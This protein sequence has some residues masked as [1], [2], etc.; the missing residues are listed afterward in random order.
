MSEAARLQKV[1]PSHLIYAFSSAKPFLIQQ[2]VLNDNLFSGELPVDG[3]SSLRGLKRFEVSRRVKV[4]GPKFSGPLPAFDQMPELEVLT[5]ANN[6]FFGGIHQKFLNNSQSIYIV[7]LRHNRLSGAVPERLASLPTLV[8]LLAGNE[9]SFLSQDFCDNNDWMAG[10]VGKVGNNGCN[11]ILCPPHTSSPLGRSNETVRCTSCPS[12]NETSTPAPYFGSTTCAAPV[13]E[14]DVLL[15]LFEACK[16][17]DWHRNDFW[18]SPIDFCDWYGVGCDINGHVVVLNLAANNLRGTTPPSIFDLPY[19]QILYIHS[20]PI[21]FIFD[22]IENA[23]NLLDLRLGSTGLT[24]LQG[25]GNAKSLTF[26]DVSF[27][28]LAGKFPEE[29]LQ[30][31]NL[32]VLDIGENSFSGPLPT[33]FGSLPYL[34]V[35]QSYSNE[36]TGTL[37]SFNDSRVLH[38]I[39]F[40]R[41]NLTG[42][43]PIDFLNG[44]SKNTNL[45]VDLSHNYLTGAIPKELGRFD[46]M[47]IYLRMNQIEE[48]PAILCSKSKWN[49]GDVGVYGCDAILCS[50]GYTTDIG[51]QS[52]STAGCV[53]CYQ[54]NERFYGQSDCPSHSVDQE[55][56]AFGGFARRTL[57]TTILAAAFILSQFQY[58][59]L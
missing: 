35:L 26:L 25:V 7:D 9:I 10:I 50:P 59:L 40:A 8:L 2:S 32:R 22:N 19:L 1:E 6:D 14:R 12:N 4:A 51:R 46:D 54:A 43:I 56:S 38:K 53:Q 24:T 37:P 27:N 49:G 20:N 29:L 55:S 48:L 16:G 58:Q 31:K 18:N 39:Y 3:I 34:R 44:I 42:T 11:A 45:T 36:F 30:L 28:A 52:S 21:D 15:E 5:L 17:N 23:R 47:A 41:N 57:P 13:S 33:S